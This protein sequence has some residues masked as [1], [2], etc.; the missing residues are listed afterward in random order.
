MPPAFSVITTVYNKE[1]TIS[2]C[3]SSI[4]SQDYQEFEIIIV[5]DRSADRSATPLASFPGEGRIRIVKTNHVGHSSAK[6]SGAKIATGKILYFIDADCV[7]DR[8]CLNRLKTLFDQSDVSCVGGELRA[9]N[10]D[11][12]IPRAIEIWQNPF[13]QPPGANVAYRREAFEKAGG[14]DAMIEFGE[15]VD[16]YWRVRKLGLKYHI[17]PSV[18]VRT[19]DPQTILDFLKQRFR[20][21]IGYAQVT[22]RHHEVIDNEMKVSFRLFSVTLLSS[23][24][25]FLDLRLG[26]IFLAFDCAV[27]LRFVRL[28]RRL[29]RDRGNADYW[30]ILALLKLLHAF[31]YY[32]GYYYWKF[33]TLFR[34]RERCVS[35]S[36]TKVRSLQL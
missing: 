20:W 19:V 29:A 14:F 2:D 30:M 9:L 6:N 26:I 24:L 34:G 4:L 28:G 17:D 31:A 3:I 15:D 8:G 33:L 1:E 18:K 35:F 5:D 25:M 27:V 10:R 22:Q 13:Q 12:L 11:H 7:A 21:G 16:L 32:L 23:L 36:M